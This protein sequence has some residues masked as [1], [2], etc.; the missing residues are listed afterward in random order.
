MKQFLLPEEYSGEKCIS[1]T[2]RDRHYLLNVQRKQEGDSFFCSDR[3]GNLYR[4][5]IESVS[6][7]SCRLSLIPRK[8]DAVRAGAEIRLFQCLPKGKKTDLILRQAV[9]AGITRISPVLSE[10]VVIRIPS[11]QEREKKLARWNKIIREACQ[12]S[13]MTPPPILDPP[14]ELESVPECLPT[15]FTGI[16]FLIPMIPLRRPCMKPFGKPGKE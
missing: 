6:D 7:G 2:D 14:V 1:L 16:F 5:V 15:D 9:E 10:R 3:E 4:A 11:G 8:P 13:G 12:Q